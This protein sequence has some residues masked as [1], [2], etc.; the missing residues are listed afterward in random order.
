MSNLER[1]YQRV[2]RPLA[3]MVYLFICVIDFVI[4]PTIVEHKQVH[5]NNYVLSQIQLFE[6]PAVQVALVNKLQLTNRWE[7]ITLQGAGLFHLS[8]GAILG[9]AAWSRGKEK[10]KLSV[11]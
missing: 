2:W 7:P 6:E 10:E 3:A 1:W 9:V 4:F 11:D 5:N 8:F